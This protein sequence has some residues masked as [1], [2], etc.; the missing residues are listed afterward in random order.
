MIRALEKNKFLE[1]KK[2]F[3][4]KAININ[5]SENKWSKLTDS[6]ETNLD[7]TQ[8]S[9][10]NASDYKTCGSVAVD[11]VP[12]NWIGTKWNDLESWKHQVSNPVEFY[13]TLVNVK[14]KGLRW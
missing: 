10:P 6:E 9:N 14:L 5:K 12:Y 7:S 11:T 1:I 3:P 4:S 13:V 2:Y 8:D